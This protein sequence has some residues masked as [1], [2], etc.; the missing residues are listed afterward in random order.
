MTAENKPAMGCRPFAGR[1]DSNS[2]R[3]AIALDSIQGVL[4]GVVVDE[5]EAVHVSE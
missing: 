4:V 3:A 1:D 5:N 2:A